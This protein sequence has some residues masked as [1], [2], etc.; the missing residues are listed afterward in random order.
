MRDLD[1]GPGVIVPA[2]LLRAS[3]SRSGGPGGQNVNKL[4]TKVTIEL[5]VEAL[6]L[7]DAQRALVQE[8]LRTRITREGV[9]KVTSQSER[10]QLGNR[11]RALDRMEELLREALVPRVPRRATRV[12]RGQKEKRRT[13][14]KRLAEK[15]RL[16]GRPED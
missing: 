10:S 2:Q 16:R 5:D 3:A 14:K 13:E 1:I 8:R 6:P 11:D 7:S 9:L 15:K 12:P 4:E